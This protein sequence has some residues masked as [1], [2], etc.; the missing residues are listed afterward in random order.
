VS[1]RSSARLFLLSILAF[2]VVATSVVWRRSLGSA[3]ARRL[4]VL[5]MQRTE[6]EAERARL[7]GE[8]RR[9]TS[10]VELVPVVARLGMRFPSDSQVV[11]LPV[12]IQDSLRR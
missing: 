4:H 3:A 2:L 11:F 9:A 5:V 1:R 12:R 10:Q 7:L 8:I 6:L